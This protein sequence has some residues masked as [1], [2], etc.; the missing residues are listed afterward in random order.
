[1]YPDGRPVGDAD[2]QRY[3]ASLNLDGVAVDNPLHFGLVLRR[4]PMRKFP[5][6]DR[7]LRHVDDPHL[8]R[9][10]ENGLFPGNALALLHRSADGRWWFAQSYNYAAWVRA[11]DVAVGSRS[12]VLDYRSAEP[13]IVVTG[14]TVRTNFNP[15]LPPLSELQLDMGVRLPAVPREEVGHSV[16]GQNPYASHVVRLPLRNADGRLDF[17]PALI[18]YS[19]DVHEGPLPLTRANLLR[20]AFKFLGERYGWGHDYNGRDCTGFV[21]E[22][23]RS[24]GILLPRNSGDQGRSFLGSNTRFADD[25]PTAAKERYLADLD[26]GDL[27]YIP[28]HVM[29]VIGHVDGEPYVMH[30]VT[31][32][33]YYDGDGNF[34]QGLLHG[35]AVTPLRPLQHTAEQSFVDRIYAIKRIR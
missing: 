17:A 13:S 35:V 6:M 21:G 5:T 3:A 25:T 8:D 9:F 34:Y 4:T 23:Y 14:S 32:L 15:D 10:Q 27:V 30:D 7:V 18:A 12:Q 33:S 19:R 2:W 29:L 16:H 20:Q 24:F 1:V 31:G 28:G 22:V 26:V 11:D